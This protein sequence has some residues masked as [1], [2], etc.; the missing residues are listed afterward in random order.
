MVENHRPGICYIL[1][2]YDPATGSHFFN[3]YQ[4]LERARENLD[5]FL[6]IE[7]AKL[8]PGN[9]PFRFY[10]QRFSFPPLR[11]GE[12]LFILMRERMRGRRYF[13]THYSFYGALASWFVTAFFGGVSYY[14]NC[15]APWLYRRSFFEETVF[16]FAMRHNILVT[17][18]AGIAS[19]YGRRYRLDRKRIIILPNWIKILRFDNGHDRGSA[20]KRFGVDSNRKI[21]LFVHRLSRRKGAHVIVPVVKSVTGQS[22]NVIFVIVGDGPELERLRLEVK[23]QGLGRFVRLIGSVPNAEIENYFAAADV[24]FMPSE[25]EGFPHVLLEAM[26]AGVPYVASNVGGVGEITPPILQKYIVRSGDINGFAAKIVELLTEPTSDMRRTSEEEKGWVKK[27]D[28]N[29]VLP[30]FIALFS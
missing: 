1:P 27:Y 9:A 6:V 5:I 12:L 10:C 13:Y 20:K 25:E 23:N 29:K 7:K 24:F 8:L 19:E 3:L 26:A 14:W 15:G 22:K 4:L 30:K 11:F 2:M 17:G 21:V 18:T 16:R 28:L